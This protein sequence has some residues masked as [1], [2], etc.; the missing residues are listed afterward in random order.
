[1]SGF[2]QNHRMAGGMNLSFFAKGTQ[3]FGVV[4]SQP[5]LIFCQ[6][7]EPP[8]ASPAEALPLTISVNNVTKTSFDFQQN[9]LENEFS[10]T[11]FYWIA[12]GQ[13]EVNSQ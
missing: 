10:G 11:A 5:P 6:I 12:I 1:M 4:F 2:L 8:Y 3:V 7:I 9:G 13:E